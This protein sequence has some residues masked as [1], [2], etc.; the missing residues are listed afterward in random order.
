MLTAVQRQ[1]IECILTNFGTLFGAVMDVS[2]AAMGQGILDEGGQGAEPQI[3]S[4]HELAATV[5]RNR[6]TGDDAANLARALACV[7]AEH[8]A[9]IMGAARLHPGDGAKLSTALTDA[10]LAGILDRYI[11]GDR[12]LDEVG[13]ALQPVVTELQKLAG[14]G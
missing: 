7:T 3:P 6:P 1:E 13:A 2:F 9:L 14:I 12:R 8:G 10:E 5:S 11:R 4:L